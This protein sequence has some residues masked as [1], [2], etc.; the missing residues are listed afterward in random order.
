MLCHGDRAVLVQM[1][2]YAAYAADGEVLKAAI[3]G[4]HEV[5]RLLFKPPSPFLKKEQSA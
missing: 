4:G 3:A 5:V 1:R 2:A